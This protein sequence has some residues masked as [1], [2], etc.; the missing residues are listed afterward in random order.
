MRR[1]GHKNC[2][3]IDGPDR[4]NAKTCTPTTKVTQLP[5]REEFASERIRDK[6]IK[7]KKEMQITQVTQSMIQFHF[8]NFYRKIH[9]SL[10][11]LEISKR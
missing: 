11:L 4:I 1:T 9:F 10:K 2:L 8:P 6:S 5:D 3:K 7:P